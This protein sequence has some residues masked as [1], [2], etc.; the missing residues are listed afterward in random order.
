MGTGGQFSLNKHQLYL[1]VLELLDSFFGLKS[2][3]KSSDT[4]AK[5]LSENAKTVYGINKMGSNNSNTCHK[6]IFDIWD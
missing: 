3:V 4:H 5:I 2:F 6:T 1:N